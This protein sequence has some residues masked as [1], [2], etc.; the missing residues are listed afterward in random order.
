MSST[1]VVQSFI[2][3]IYYREKI[4]NLSNYFPIIFS[5]D[6]SHLRFAWP[7]SKLD[8]FRF[9]TSKY[10]DKFI[11]LHILDSRRAFVR[12][13]GKHA[14]KSIARAKSRAF[15]MCAWANLLPLCLIAQSIGA[16]LAFSI[17]TKRERVSL[18]V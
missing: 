12:F 13:R 9:I 14:R 11:V 15:T 3:E 2:N 18:R 5:S 1:R 16:T 7:H 4:K 10:T 6:L 8:S 17:Y